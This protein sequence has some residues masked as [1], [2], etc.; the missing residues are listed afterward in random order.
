MSERGGARATPDRKQS[1]P[2]PRSTTAGGLACTTPPRLVLCRRQ[3][4]D[5][6]VRRGGRQAPLAKILQIQV[7]CRGQLT[8]DL[9]GRFASR[10]AARQIWQIRPLTQLN[11][12][13]QLAV[14][15]QLLQ[16]LQTPVGAPFFLTT[17][18][19]WWKFL[20]QEHKAMQ[21]CLSATLRL[22]LAKMGSF[23][24]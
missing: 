22:R 10:R 23:R 20:P 3:R 13:N 15:L 12:R 1:K 17:L 11:M 7:H 18:R 5:T 4:A 9:L 21:T 2:P 6:R 19:L 8:L 16:L 24:L 14:Q